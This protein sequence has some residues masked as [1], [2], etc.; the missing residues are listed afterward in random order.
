MENCARP[1][2]NAH[3][4]LARL[5]LALCLLAPSRPAPARPDRLREALDAIA[6][7]FHGTLGYSLHHLKTGDR[8]ERAGDERFPT[9][10]TIKLAM[11][12]AAMEKQQKGEIGYDE[13]RI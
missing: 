1:E 5:L 4:V 8:L 7:R 9:A 11:L 6:N 2:R 13:Q 3:R 10:S 12:C